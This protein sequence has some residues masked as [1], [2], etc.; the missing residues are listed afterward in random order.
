METFRETTWG[1]GS[2]DK[3]LQGACARD[4]SWYTETSAAGR[5]VGWGVTWG[6]TKG[7]LQL[8]FY[9]SVRKESEGLDQGRE[10]GE[11]VCGP[12]SWPSG[13]HGLQ[14]SKG[15]SPK[16]GAGRQWRE[17][18]KERVVCEVHGRCGQASRCGASTGPLLQ[19]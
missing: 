10:R 12:T 8:L 14:L 11:K 1:F 16:L 13:K 3:V 6:T 4:G 9:L 5:K 7:R 15:C 18:D 17:E 2:C 19:P